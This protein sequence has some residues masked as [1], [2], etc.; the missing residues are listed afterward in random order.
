M[1]EEVVL[2]ATYHRL[3]KT[4]QLLIRNVSQV[5]FRGQVR[6]LSPN[7]TSHFPARSDRSMNVVST[8]PLMNSAVFMIS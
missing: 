8:L 1:V 5:H 7:G 3:P 4:S 2:I 6:F